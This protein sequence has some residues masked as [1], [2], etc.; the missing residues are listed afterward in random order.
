MGQLARQV[1]IAS[2]VSDYVVRLVLATH[3]DTEQAA[4][5][6]SKY[7]RYGAS[8]RGAQAIVMAAKIRALIEGRLNV[9]FE[10]VRAVTSP[11]LRHRI[12]LNFEAEASGTSAD[13]VI[14]GLLTQVA[15]TA[16]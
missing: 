6:V 3:P 9:A 14:D 16:V 5:I 4:P 15:E 2:H 1:P 12:I 11:A 10:D 13:D 7:V 8:P